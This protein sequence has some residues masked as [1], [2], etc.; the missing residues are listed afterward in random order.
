MARIAFVFVFVIALPA[1]FALEGCRK[2]PPTV[3]K[4]PDATATPIVP[5]IV[6]T[7][8]GDPMKLDGV[9]FTDAR[10]ARAALGDASAA[11]PIEVRGVATTPWGRVIQGIDIA[12]QIGRVSFI[13]STGTRK[14]HPF[15]LPRATAGMPMLDASRIAILGDGSLLHDDTKLASPAD[16]A[17]AIGDASNARVVIMAD[18]QA[19][20]GRVIDV[21]LEIE[22]LGRSFAFGVAPIFAP[23]R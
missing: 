22:R 7:V 21:V 10:S 4:E 15:E 8:D 5:T 20:L 6:M 17:A 12:K 13:V 16:L 19:E 2:D 23:P 9:P 14:T 11:T 1:L 3:T 18:A